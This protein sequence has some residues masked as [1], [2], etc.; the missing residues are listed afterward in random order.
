MFLYEYLSY[1]SKQQ[2]LTENE[3]NMRIK[4]TVV[5]QKFNK[6]SKTVF[7]FFLA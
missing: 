6:D 7:V 1:R 3:K 5:F 2:I 4:A